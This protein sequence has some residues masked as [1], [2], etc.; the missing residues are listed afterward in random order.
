MEKLEGTVKIWNADQGFGFIEL[1]DAQDVFVHYSGIVAPHVRDLV[2]GQPVTFVMVQG[3][4]GWQAAGVEPKE[5]E[6][7]G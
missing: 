1:P 6:Y 7:H 2:V 4:R 5:D 3:A